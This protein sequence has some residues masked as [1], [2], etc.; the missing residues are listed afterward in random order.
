MSLSVSTL[1]NDITTHVGVA[2]K[3]SVNYLVARFNDLD[4]NGAKNVISSKLSS[5]P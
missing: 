3:E 2:T 1:L 5:L 4:L